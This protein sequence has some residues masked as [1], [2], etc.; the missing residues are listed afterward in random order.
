MGLEQKAGDDC[1]AVAAVR[2][3]KLIE[4]REAQRS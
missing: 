4:S 3:I 2:I 1:N